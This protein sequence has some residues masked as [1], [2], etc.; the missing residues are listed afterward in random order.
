MEY[1]DSFVSNFLSGNADKLIAGYKIIK[2][3]IK[4]DF[5]IS[6]NTF[7]ADIMPEILKKIK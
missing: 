1:S 5:L 3:I 2:D 4:I 7:I 6:L